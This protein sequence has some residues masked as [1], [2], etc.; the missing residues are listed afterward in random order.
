MPASSQ[1]T[2][3]SQWISY[4][5]IR[6]GVSPVR[7]RYGA[8]GQSALSIEALYY[9]DKH[10]R[11]LESPVHPGPYL[12]VV[13]HLPANVLPEDSAEQWLVAAQLM[14]RD[15]RLRGL[16]S[17]LALPPTIVDVRPWLWEGFL[18]SPLYTYYVDLPHDRS[19]VRTQ[20]KGHARQAAKAGY[21][22]KQTDNLNDVVDC[23]NDSQKRQN[24]DIHLGL[25]DLTVLQRELGEDTL[26][27][28]V[29]YAPDGEPASA[30]VNIHETGGAVINWLAGTKS[31]HLSSGINQLL[32][33]SILDDVEK[34]GASAF[35]FA[36]A[37]LQSVATAKQQWGGRLKPFYSIDGGSIT[38]LARDMRR[39]WR[40]QRARR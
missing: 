17:K 3:D 26:R 9:L 21:T 39:Y 13:T 6:W 33:A 36:G 1:T 7:V 25:L 38:E 2:D 30:S 27:T 16:A 20:V 5:K 8:G 18:V 32:T 24:F 35:D 31:S 37:N 11:I 4:C 22:C 15:M 29:G 23:L 28:Y 40:Y 34:A 12:S 10:G 19:Q 14:A